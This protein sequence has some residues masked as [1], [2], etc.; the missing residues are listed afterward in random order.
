MVKTT[1][2]LSSGRALICVWTLL[3]ALSSTTSAKES[4]QVTCG[5]VIKL[6]HVRTGHKLH[7]H[8]IAYGSG[9]GQQSVTGADTEDD[10]NSFWV[11]RG[12]QEKPC[13]QGTPLKKG[14]KLRLQHHST[15]KWL[16]SHNFRSPLSQNLEVSCFGGEDESDLGDVWQL[17]WDVSA[18]EWVKDMQVRFSHVVTKGLLSSHNAKFGRPIN[19][20]TEVCGMTKSGAHALWIATEGVYFPT[21]QDGEAEHTEL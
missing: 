7:S 15:R 4:T 14:D 8:D 18:K 11:V 21:H 6:S 19:G 2:L 5:S 16:H 12:L 17:Q 3:L 20:Q 9:S 13:P 10:A 1:M